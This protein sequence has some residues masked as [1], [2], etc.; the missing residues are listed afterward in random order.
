M[1]RQSINC[2]QCG[3]SFLAK[4]YEVRD[5]RRFCSTLCHNLSKRNTPDMFW[6]K[7]QKTSSCWLWTGKLT[8]DGYGH[9]VMKLASGHKE[10]LAHRVAYVF[11]KGMVPQ[12]LQ[13]DHL[14]RNRACVNPA[15]LEPV[16]QRENVLRGEGIAAK[17]SRAT[18]CKHGHL[19]D[20]ANT[21]MRKSGGRFCRECGRI[22]YKAYTTRKRA[23]LLNGTGSL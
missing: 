23:R 12:G 17:E 11:E 20:A 10:I 21:M 16:T 3:T 13:L 8:R 5:G 7:V 18:H 14:C 6:A 1:Q 22:R 2:A 4:N 19:F 9:F 15:H